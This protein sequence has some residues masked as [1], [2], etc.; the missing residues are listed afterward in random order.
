MILLGTDLLEY[1]TDF[2][3]IKNDKRIREIGQSLCNFIKDNF[4]PSFNLENFIT[5]VINDDTHYLVD[6][7]TSTFS[8]YRLEIHQVTGEVQ[9]FTKYKYINNDYTGEQIYSITK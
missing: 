5:T 2:Y 3:F 9:Y 1:I 8:F 6:L 7:V 4:N